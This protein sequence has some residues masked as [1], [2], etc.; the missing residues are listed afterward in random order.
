MAAEQQKRQSRKA[1]RLPAV[2]W[3]SSGRAEGAALVAGDT[4]LAP[5][6]AAAYFD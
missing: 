5:G 6:M 2:R 4:A 1:S 3:K